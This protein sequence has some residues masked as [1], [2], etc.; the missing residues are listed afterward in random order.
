MKTL[1]LFTIFVLIFGTASTSLVSDAYAQNDL[2]ILL[3]IAEQADKQIKNQL[4]RSYGN[5]IP[6]DIK[7]LHDQGH[8]AVESLKK[9]LPDD[10]EQARENFL[11][12]MK[13]FKQISKMI[14]E[15]IEKAT[16]SKSTRVADRDLSSELD[17]LEKYVE[18]LKTISKKHNTGITFDEI[19]TLIESARTQIETE[20]AP[21]IIDQ[22]KDHVSSIQQKIRDSSSDSTSDRIKQFVEKQLKTINKKLTKASDAGATADQIGEAVTLIDQ[23]ESSIENN[24]IGNAKLVFYELNKLVKNI[25]RSVR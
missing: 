20:T 23:I 22:L 7:D 8:K 1:A 18:N 2:N 21:E 16:I 15:P 4:D 10:V 17:R 6:S 9:S 13:S 14:S 5:S 12:A 19:D 24:D 25:E 3:R 11:I